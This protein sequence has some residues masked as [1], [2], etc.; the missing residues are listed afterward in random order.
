MRMTSG[1]K[2]GAA[3]IYSLLFLM[4][5]VTL[6]PFWHVLMYS[7]S[8]PL[9]AMEG[10]LFLYPRGLSLVSYKMVIDSKGIFT[11]YGNSIFRTVVGTSINLLLTASIAYPLSLRRLRGRRVIAMLIFFT[12]LFSG[13]MIPIYLL[14]RSLGLL[15]NRFALILPGAVSAFNMFILRNYFQSL[16]ASLEESANMDGATPLRI[17]FSI[18]LPV[19]MPA[20]AA[21]AL[22]YAVDH[23]NAFFDAILYINS[24]GKQVLQVFLRVMY[25]SSALNSV[26]GSASFDRV[27]EITEDSLRMAVVSLSIL[28]MLAL[29]PFLQKYYVKGVLIGSVKG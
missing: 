18:V 12:M 16:P 19:S 2:T 10:G 27:S 11:A 14:V 6:Y 24:T 23:W 21:V 9:K 20:I 13:G 22:F 4:M 25:Q 26:A 7:L 5:I 15:N 3:V 29:Y 17:L 8:Q 1:E 28:P